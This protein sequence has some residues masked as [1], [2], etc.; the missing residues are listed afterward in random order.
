MDIK[1]PKTVLQ[2]INVHFKESESQ[3]ISATKI[4][5]DIEECY[6]FSDT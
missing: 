3:V 4:K 1:L 2:I 5:V 6:G